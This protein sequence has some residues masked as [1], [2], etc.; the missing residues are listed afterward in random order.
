M[1]YE[2]TTYKLRNRTVGKV[3]QRLGEL[4]EKRSKYSALAASWHTEI[5]PLNQVV[6]IWP[7]ADMGERER[8]RAAAEKDRAWPP[9][10]DE[11][12]LSERTEIMVPFAFS[13][14][15]APAE[16]GPFFEM[17]TYTYEA[18][19]LPKIIA[20]W[21][22]SIPAR[23]AFGPVTAL[24]HSV[25]G[26]RNLFINIWPYRSLDERMR[27]REAARAAGVW[28]PTELAEKRGEPGYRL[29]NL[30]NTILMPASFSPLR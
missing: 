19:E 7:Y 10:I 11:F 25:L 21:E 3:E 14:P 13:P 30:E 28:P 18:G 26:A 9:D 16:V 8:I 20:L 24:M 1:L 12:V 29:Q 5:G 22:K 23:L 17:R 4:L 2:V 27:I 6:Q 15:L